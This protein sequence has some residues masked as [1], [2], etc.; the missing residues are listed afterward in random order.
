MFDFL[1]IHY[2]TWHLFVMAFLGLM[3][4]G[5]WLCIK[6]DREIRSKERRQ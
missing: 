2:K 5:L 3:V 1:G 4:R 6:E